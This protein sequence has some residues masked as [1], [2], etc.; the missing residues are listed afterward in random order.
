MDSPVL[1]NVQVLEKTFPGLKAD[2]SSPLDETGRYLIISSCWNLLKDLPL[3]RRHSQTAQAHWGV[4]GDNPRPAQHEETNFTCC[5]AK[6][7]ELLVLS[8]VNF[9]RE[10]AHPAQASWGPFQ[11]E[12]FNGAVTIN[13]SLLH[14]MLFMFTWN[15]VSTCLSL[16]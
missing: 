10:P 2:F 16:H 15:P 8:P 4:R 12:L 3:S 6:L 9:S 5:T 11:P 13:W 7:S 1:H 14:Q